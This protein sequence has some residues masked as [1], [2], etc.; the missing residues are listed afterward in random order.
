M[1]WGLAG[2]AK[3]TLPFSR[4]RILKVIVHDRKSASVLGADGGLC[5]INTTACRRF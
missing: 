2:D 5:A 1:H 3:S 4:A